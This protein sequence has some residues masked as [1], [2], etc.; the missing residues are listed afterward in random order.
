M[1]KIIF[2][3]SAI[4][5]LLK[6]EEGHKIAAERLDDAII[7]SVNFSEVLTVIARRGFGQKEV[8]KSLKNTFLHIID[9]DAEQAIIAASLDEIT[10]KH[11]LGLGG[12]AC[13]ALAKYKKLPV[14]TADQAWKKLKIDVDVRLIR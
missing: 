1:N 2:D 8:I 3:S 14:L 11:G 4:L 12:R 9:F 13:L 5:A 10:K 7:S 6:M